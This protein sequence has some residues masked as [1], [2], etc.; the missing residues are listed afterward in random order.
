MCACGSPD[1]YAETFLKEYE[2][3][4]G[5]MLLLNKYNISYEMTIIGRVK[6]L[7]SSIANFLYQ[8][9][10]KHTIVNAPSEGT[11]NELFEAYNSLL[12]QLCSRDKI[13]FP[14]HAVYRLAARNDK[15]PLLIKKLT[16]LMC[17][18]RNISNSEENIEMLRC[19][20]LKVF[21]LIDIDDDMLNNIFDLLE[22]S[23]EILIPIYKMIAYYIVASD[24]YI[25][26]NHCKT[27]I[28]RL[29]AT[30]GIYTVNKN[31]DPLSVENINKSYNEN[32]QSDFTRYLVIIKLLVKFG[33]ECTAGIESSY[34]RMVNAQTI[35]LINNYAYGRNTHAYKVYKILS[36]IPRE[37]LLYCD[38]IFL[39][40]MTHILYVPGGQGAQNAA[41]DFQ[42][43][44]EDC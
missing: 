20:L 16:K 35:S 31:Y 41:K 10:E 15:S 2:V 43:H 23:R 24:C 38:I 33:Y 18:K 7:L 3:L 44:I 12:L 8:M 37:K 21:I 42:Q 1:K 40:I 9:S 32:I 5:T 22:G 14:V 11:I 17:A 19:W 4:S 25:L 30:F 13:V 29:I 27:L 28:K 39:D 36:Q 6:V 34:I 26:N